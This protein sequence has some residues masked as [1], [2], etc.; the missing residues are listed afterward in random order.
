MREE[1]EKIHSEETATDKAVKKL[2]EAF[3]E[4]ANLSAE[5]IE[6]EILAVPGAEEGEGLEKLRKKSK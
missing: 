2:E 3:D 1:M 6:K 5:E 4:S